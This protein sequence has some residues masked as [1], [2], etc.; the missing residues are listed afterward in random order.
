MTWEQ[1]EHADRV[2]RRREFERTTMGERLEEAI[3]LSKAVSE[4][5]QSRRRRAD[6][7]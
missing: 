3:K 5:A 1:M 6:S 4:L 2:R 7:S